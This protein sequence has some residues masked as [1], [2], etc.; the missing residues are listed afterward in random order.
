[1]YAIHPAALVAVA[2][3]GIVGVCV[4]GFIRVYLPHSRRKER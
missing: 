1:M 3:L 2:V 4:D